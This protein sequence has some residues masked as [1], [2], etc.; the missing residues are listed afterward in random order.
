MFLKSL[1]LKLILI[2]FILISTTVLGIGVYSIKKVEE[3]YYNGFIEE[4]L[5]TI[6]SFGLNIKHIK[7]EETKRTDESLNVGKDFINK[8]NQVLINEEKIEEEREEKLT[9]ET[10]KKIYA[11][12]N[13]YFSLNNIS[14]RGYLLNKDYKE[15]LT[16][17]TVSLTDI[18]KECIGDAQKDSNHFFGMKDKSANSYIFAYYINY[19][20]EKENIEFTKEEVDAKAKEM[21][22]NYGISV[23][24]LIKAYGTIDIVKY[25]MTMHKALEIIK[26]NN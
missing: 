8:K 7:D 5:N 6:S 25:D 2:F 21:A 15:L 24:E 14:R 16:N 17:Q 3:V 20:F 13:I 9:Q 1:Q 19:N 10:I 12:F 4:M 23:D 22:E 18:A 26:E 11:N